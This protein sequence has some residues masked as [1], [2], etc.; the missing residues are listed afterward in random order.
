MPFVEEDHAI[1][2][3]VKTIKSIFSSLDDGVI[4]PSAYDT[5]WVALIEGVNEQ[6]GG[7]QFPSSLEWIENHQL[8]DGSWGESMIFSAS[9]RLVNTLACVI[10][11]TT[12]KVHP[13]KCERV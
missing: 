5:A 3:Y 4:S 2:N 8:L 7:P 9:D 1:K 11:L 10:A 13:D 6:S 12:W